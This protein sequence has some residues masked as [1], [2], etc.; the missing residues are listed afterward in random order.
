MRLAEKAGLDLKSMEQVVRAGAAQSRVAD[1]WSRQR[2]LGDTYTT[3]QRGFADLIYKDLRLALELGHDVGVPLPG[4]ALA[5][6]SIR[7]ILDMKD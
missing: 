4:A 2:S 1:H 7:R 3:G 5:Q 6:Q